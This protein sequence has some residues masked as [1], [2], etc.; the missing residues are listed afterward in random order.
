M[1]YD[2]ALRLKAIYLVYQGRERHD[3]NVIPN[4]ANRLLIHPATIYEWLNQYE[5]EGIVEPKRI[6]AP[7]PPSV[8]EEHWGFISNHLA[9]KPDLYMSEIRELVYIEY[10]V[11][12]PDHILL[13]A[14]HSHGFTRKVIENQA[15]LQWSR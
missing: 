14:L 2:N 13:S 15:G 10:D 3:F 8:S 4:V 6:R 9:Y 1:T 11:V 7:P 12:Y 5:R